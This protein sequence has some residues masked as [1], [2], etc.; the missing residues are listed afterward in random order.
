MAVA[1]LIGSVI[2]TF[3]DLILFFQILGIYSGSL[4]SLHYVMPSS[5]SLDCWFLTLPLLTLV[6]GSLMAAKFLSLTHLCLFL[7]GLAPSRWIKSSMVI[8]LY[9]LFL[10]SHFKWATR[11]NSCF[12][13]KRVLSLV[14]FFFWKELSP[15]SCYDTHTP[16]VLTEATLPFRVVYQHFP[17]SIF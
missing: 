6:G 10:M 8:A 3:W 2:S 1:L 7:S 16:S 14:F 5:E 15:I 13:G 4:C 17:L 9:W 12:C 11:E